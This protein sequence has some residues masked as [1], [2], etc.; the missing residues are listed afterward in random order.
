MMREI[1]KG[2][3]VFKKAL[4]GAG[5]ST[6]SNIQIKGRKCCAVSCGGGGSVR[7]G[8]AGEGNRQ[9]WAASAWRRE[10]SYVSVL[11]SGR[12]ASVREAQ[13]LRWSR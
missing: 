3:S 7:S 11:T 9:D 12:L 5:D 10:Q 2:D 1:F 4:K 8:P 6:F 13:W